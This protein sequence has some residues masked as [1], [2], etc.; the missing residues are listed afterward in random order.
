MCCDVSRLLRTATVYFT[1]KG[2]NFTIHIRMLSAEVLSSK[3][4]DGKKN[5]K[6][7]KTDVKS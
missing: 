4:R 3:G 7:D 5:I 1:T 2:S 6:T